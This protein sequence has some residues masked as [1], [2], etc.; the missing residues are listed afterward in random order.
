MSD[1]SAGAA[2]PRYR[3][4][5][6]YSHADARFAGWLHRK[7]ERHRLPDRTA[8]SPIFIDRAELAAGP[9]LS[10][11]VRA[12][13]AQSAA[14]IVVA[15]PA[16]R[17]SRWVAREI[18]LYR[19]LNPGRPI[20]AA[21][22]AG[23][24]GEAF[25]DALLSQGGEAVEPLAAD[26]RKGHDGQRLGLLK[27]IA[28]L[29]DQPLDRLV[30]RDAQS[31]QRRV[32]AITAGALLLSLILSAA[33]IVAI[34]ARSEAERQRAEAEGLV[35]FMLTDL[36]DKLKGVGRLDVMDA[37]ND[38]VTERYAKEAQLD[39]LPIDL[40]LRRARLLHAM[41]EDDFSKTGGWP[42]GMREAEEALRITTVQIARNPADPAVLMTHAQSEYWLGYGWFLNRKSQGQNRDRVRR[43]WLNYA[44]AADRLV[45][46]N[47]DNPD[48]QT[49]A[50][51]AAA[52]LCALELTD[53]ADPLA[54]LPHCRRSKEALQRVAT[55]RPA[56]LGSQLDL[57]SAIAW[58]A[59]AALANGDPAE[60]QRLRQ[61]QVG[62][63]D[64]LAA[65][66]PR[67]RRV[68]EG[69]VLARMGLAKVLLRQGRRNEATVI[70]RQAR[71]ALEP[72]I[73][74]DPH[75]GDWRSWLGQIDTMQKQL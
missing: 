72:L 35:E 41:A 49:E 75:N 43:H 30:Q 31:R 25:P 16:A 60:A 62:M 56:D 18:A 37:V 32:M 28:G 42:R 44:S 50:G 11:Q 63:L 46:I 67:D 59:D 45:R 38:R 17:A 61:Q 12:A 71:S 52:N 7:L 29:T 70:L 20:Y 69:G 6:S 48:W 65:A 27:I 21:L 66:H 39:S 36:R 55:L 26:F 64:T 2:G 4:F 74:I 13:L 19:E 3:A 34:R 58:E 53:Q 57:A 1:D 73:T 23:E 8:L 24:P 51:S 15:S 14:L 33:L 9:D 10:A 68:Q 47:P 40:V 5:I 54:A 22:I